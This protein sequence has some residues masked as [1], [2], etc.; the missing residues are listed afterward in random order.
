MLDAIAT[1]VT[2]LVTEA[3]P[4]RGLDPDIVRPGWLAFWIFVGLC[5]A[6]YVLMRSFARHARMARQPW[7]GEQAAADAADPRHESGH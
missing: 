6:L 4:T 7:E 3:P 1:A 2:G 5:V